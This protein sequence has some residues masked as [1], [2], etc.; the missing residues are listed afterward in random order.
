M[1]VESIPNDEL[2]AQ[3]EKALV[4]LGNGNVEAAH[5]IFKL[6]VRANSEDSTA[7]IGLGE[8]LEQMSNPMGAKSAYNQARRVNP[9]SFLAAHG[10]GRSLIMLDRPQMAVAALKDAIALD[11]NS[12]ATWCDLGTA[13]KN[14]QRYPDA[15]DSFHN[16]LSLNPNFSL[17]HLNLGNCFR[18]QGDLKKAIAH[19]EKA[20]SLD[21]SSIHAVT[22]LAATVSDTGETDAAITVIDKH[23]KSH[24]DNVECHQNKA[25]ILLRAANLSDGFEEYEWRF[26]PSRFG[27][28]VRP[29]PRP[30]W[31]GEP[32]EDR[33]LL[34][35]LEQGIGD[36]ILSLSIWKTL[37]NS[38][39]GRRCIVECDPRLQDLLKRSFPLVTVV[40]RQTP[41][42]ART[43]ES[44]LTC[45]AWSGARFLDTT[46]AYSPDKHGYLV[47]DRAAALALRKKYE[48]LAQGRTI[49]GL[50]WSSAARKGRLKTPPIASWDALLQDED[51]F[52]V[53]LQHA[54]SEDDLA[55]LQ[56]KSRGRFYVDKPP[57]ASTNLD[58]HAAELSA[59]DAVVTISNSTAHLAG[60]LGVAV[61]TAVPSGYGGFWYWFRDRT[62]S[63]WYPSMRICRQTSPE[64][65]Q[66]AI[67]SAHEWLKTS[68][69][70][71]K[72]LSQG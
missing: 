65:W 31:R 23:L 8:C 55:H 52:F 53:N 50:S 9:E 13:Y 6:V 44:D 67:S 63:P 20:L 57:Q 62:D 45:A 18:E 22:N 5:Q 1:S 60:A 58:N 40:D 56:D 7:W 10:L 42:A 27:V 2:T 41:P 35:W 47:A 48:G 24:P 30:K 16:A 69:W 71:G 4:E 19:F 38:E 72:P 15:E 28:P 43:K 14:L 11:P 64:N 36:E 39:D 37:L 34:I 21:P 32:L 66:S 17:A 3:R 59:V 25:L 33:S 49:V 26:Q 12:E 29:F 51:Y 61:A 54:P 46:P 68:P 70:G